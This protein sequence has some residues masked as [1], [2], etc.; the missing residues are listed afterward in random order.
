[1]LSIFSPIRIVNF[2]LLILYFVSLSTLHLTLPSILYAGAPDTLWTKTYGTDSHEEGWSLQ[3]TSDGGFIIGGWKKPLGAGDEDVYLI[4]TNSNGDTLW[5]KT[6]GGNNEQYCSSIQQTS[7]GG[8]IIVGRTGSTKTSDVHLIRAN[9]NGDTLWTRTYGRS[10]Y[11][12][13][14][15]VQ[16]TSDGGFIIAGSARINDVSSPSDVY[17]IRASSNG[18]TI[19]TKT[20]GGTDFDCGNSIQ[21]TDDGGFIIGG[22]TSSFGEGLMDAYLLRIDSKG[23]TLWTKTYGGVSADECQEVQQTNDGGFVM[24]GWTN[25]FGSGGHD[26]YLVRTDS[27]GDTLWTKTYGGTSDESG[28][29]VQQTSDGGFIIGGIT[30]SFG[31][32]END[33]YLIRTNSNGDTLWTKT[34]G[35]INYDNGYSVQQTSDGGFI[36]TGWTESF[37]AGIGDVYLIRLDKETVGIQEESPNNFI[38][39]NG[40]IVSHDHANISIRYTLTYSTSVKLEAYDTQGKLVKVIQDKF[41]QKGSYSVNWDSKRFGSGVYFLQLSANG[42]AVSKKVTVIR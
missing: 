10:E 27:N 31:A 23:D 41:M 16:Q 30:N 34:Y 38:N 18:D 20:Y 42:S 8:F 25:S 13:G 1:M 21:Q 37:G 12:V 22:S 7:D 39:P 35:G 6:Y 33:I 28:F 17:L 32:G 4:R 2:S 40:F 26:F 29:S 19:W 15:S 5:T 24:G 11:D 9:S 36:V 14:S 3:Q